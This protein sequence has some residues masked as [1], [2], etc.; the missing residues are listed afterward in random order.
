MEQAVRERVLRHAVHS[1]HCDRRS[2]NAESGKQREKMGEFHAVTLQARAF[3]R[4]ALT[5]AGG[6][7]IRHFSSRRD[8]INCAELL[9]SPQPSEP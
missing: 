5:P 8:G 2:M 9:S 1:V 7:G 6:N 4:S 3:S